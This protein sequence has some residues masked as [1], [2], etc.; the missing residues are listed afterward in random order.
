MPV[1]AKNI[2]LFVPNLIGYVRI[3]LAIASFYYMPFDYVMASSCYLLSGFLDAFDGHAARLLNQGTK[4]GAML[5]QLTDRAATACLV[6]TLAHFYP[7]YMMWFQLSMALD[8]VSHWLHLHTSLMK[9]SSSHKS[10]GLD[11][12]PIMKVYYTSRPVLFV[13]CAGNELFFAMLYLLHFTE[14]PLVPVLG[15]SVIRLILYISTPIMIVKAFISLIHLVDASVR[16]AT[17]DADDRNKQ[18]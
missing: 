1:T 3:I 18:N 15:L 5:D 2:L 4:F 14:G 16:L 12:N 9:G 13:M 6:V 11:S 10:M 17:I 8:I 7:K